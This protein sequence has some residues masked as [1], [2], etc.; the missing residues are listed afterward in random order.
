MKNCMKMVLFG[1]CFCFFS[2]GDGS[3][4]VC[5][6]NIVVRMVRCCGDMKEFDLRNLMIIRKVIKIIVFY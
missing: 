2:E 6:L 3:Y 5:G 4:D 1:V